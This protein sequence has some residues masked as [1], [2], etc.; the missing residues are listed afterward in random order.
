M[1]NKLLHQSGASLVE[2]CLLIAL[3]AI[4]A[5]AGV[6]GFGKG[7]EFTY[8]DQASTI[9]ATIASE[10]ADGAGLGPEFP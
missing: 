5:L 9:S 6:R 4:I 7:V 10:G 3:I 1:H 8:G 2:Y